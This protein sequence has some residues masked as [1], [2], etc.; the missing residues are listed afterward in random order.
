MQEEIFLNK[1]NEIINETKDFIIMRPYYSYVSNKV[2]YEKNSNIYLSNL[3]K[4]EWS[5]IYHGGCL[6]SIWA[7]QDREK[8]KKFDLII[9]HQ[10]DS[11]IKNYKVAS[12]SLPEG[13]PDNI[14]DEIL[15]NKV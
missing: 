8:I 13:V 12:P 9:T 6:L 1:E 4:R 10:V 7:R 11:V 5:E 3:D 2:I 15:L 14:K